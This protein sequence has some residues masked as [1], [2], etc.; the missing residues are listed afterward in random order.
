M[1]EDCTNM[2]NIS[3]ITSKTTSK[4][5]SK[6]FILFSLNLFSHRVVPRNKQGVNIFCRVKHPESRSVDL[7]IS[8]GP[9]LEFFNTNS[10]TNTLLAP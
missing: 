9:V 3:L 5:F 8:D 1:W 10:H 6:N 4:K 2:I 7:F